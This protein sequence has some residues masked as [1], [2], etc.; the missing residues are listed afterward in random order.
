MWEALCCSREGGSWGHIAL[1]LQGNQ[2]EM[3]LDTSQTES[4]NICHRAGWPCD[5]SPALTQGSTS[6]I[7]PQDAHMW[8]LAQRALGRA[9]MR[10]DKGLLL[11]ESGAC[12]DGLSSN[13]WQGPRGVQGPPGPTG[14]PGRRVSVWCCEHVIRGLQGRQLGHWWS[15]ALLWTVPLSALWS[16]VHV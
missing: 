15:S 9:A 12:P 6:V 11:P 13:S 2:E 14:K 10:G 5:L 3:S 16:R 7:C 4:Y 1:L 8:Q